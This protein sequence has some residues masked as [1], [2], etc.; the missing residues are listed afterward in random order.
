V[1]THIREKAKARPPELL[2]LHSTRLLSLH[3][4]SIFSKFSIISGGGFKI[5]PLKFRKER[6]Y[7]GSAPYAD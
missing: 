3:G 6:P 2:L 1:S 7:L 5:C 4:T